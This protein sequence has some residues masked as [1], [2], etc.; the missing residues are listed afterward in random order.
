MSNYVF[1]WGGP[2]SQWTKSPFTIDGVTFNT[3]EQYMMYKKAMLFNDNASA[4]AIMANSNPREQK[5]L[6]RKVSNFDDAEW[7]KHAY[8]YV[9]EGNRAKFEQNADLR[10][11]LAATKG[12]LIVEASPYDKRWGIGMEEGDEGIENSDNWQGENLLGKA[13]TQVRMEMFGE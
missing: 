8:Q 3:C 4:Q 7:M 9:V 5:M 10:A 6:G 1:F 2:F 11:E 12:K 13:V